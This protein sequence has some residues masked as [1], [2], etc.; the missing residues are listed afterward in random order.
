MA[1]TQRAGGQAALAVLDVLRA[2]F[3]D[4]PT[5]AAGASARLRGIGHLRASQGVFGGR[6]ILLAANALA[7]LVE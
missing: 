6:P 4:E 2:D 7:L 3:G 1:L 5:F